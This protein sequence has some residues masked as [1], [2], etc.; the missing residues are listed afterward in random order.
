[1]LKDFASQQ[2][3]KPGLIDEYR[4]YK[5]TAEEQ[6]QTPMSPRDYFRMEFGAARLG[7]AKGGKV[8]KIMPEGV[9]YKGK[10]KDYPGIKQ[11]IKD[12]KKKGKK[13]R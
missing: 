10:A 11:L 3:L 9:L 12:A 7:V 13:K 2:A 8:I 5:Y 6:G 4:N 1:M